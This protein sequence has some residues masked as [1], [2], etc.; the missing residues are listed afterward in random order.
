M[1]RSLD[2]VTTVAGAMMVLGGLFIGPCS[3]S[4]APPPAPPGEPITWG[5]GVQYYGVDL[6][7]RPTHGDP[8]D[9]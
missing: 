8:L 9:A 5:P 7:D 4:V 2:V 6:P 1:R 3:L